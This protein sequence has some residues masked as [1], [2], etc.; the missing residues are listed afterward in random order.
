[1]F[2][3]DTLANE[4]EKLLGRASSD[5]LIG[6]SGIDTDPLLVRWVARIGGEVAA[7]SDRLNTKPEFV[8]LGSEVANALTLPG[9]KVLVTRGLLDEVTCD[10]ELA[11]VLAHEMGH[12][13]KKHAWQQL[14]NSALFALLTRILHPKSELLRQGSMIL[15]LLRA[16]AQS[17]ENE[18]QADDVGLRFATAAGYAPAGLLHFIETMASGPMAAWEEYFATHPPGAKRT[19]R[20]RSQSVVHETDADSRAAIAAGFDR[21]GFSGLAELVRRGRDP[22]ALPPVPTPTLSSRF[23]E[24]RLELVASA[25]AQQKRLRATY[26]PLVTSGMLQQLLLLTSQSQDLRFIALSTHAYLLQ[27]QIQ[28]VYARTVRLLRQAVPVWDDLAGT[29]SDDTPDRILGREEVHEAL[30]RVAGTADPLQR[31][32]KAS[33]AALSDLHLGRFYKL[34][35]GAQWTRIAAIEGLIRYGESELS[36][37]DRASGTA[38][39]YLALAR[40]RRYQHRL[41]LL[42]PQNDA[43]A[44]TLWQ[45]LLEARLGQAVSGEGATGDASIR[46]ALAVQRQT[47]EANVEARRNGQLWAQWVAQTD[48]IPENIATVLRLLTLDLERELAARAYLQ[49]KD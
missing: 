12:V 4:I 34:S 10:D 39:R 13:A 22:L 27:F 43:Q 42:A 45:T 11:G 15:N 24:E 23:R 37:A 38:W 8:V 14:Q 2:T 19:Q 26:Q 5:A 17:R 44:R 20:G 31:A 21:R 47:T 32:T 33:L 46:A 30:R 41:G 1:M 40:I 29:Q 25:I 7:H 48:G 9:S 6:A 16:L 3:P 28:D 18:Y 36:R 49:R 35:S